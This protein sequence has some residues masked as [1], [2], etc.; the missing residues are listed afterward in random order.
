MNS[1]LPDAHHRHRPQTFDERSAGIGERDRPRS[2][3]DPLIAVRRDRADR[4][5]ASSRSA[6]TTQGDVAGDPYYYAI[7]QAIYAVIGIALMLALARID[8]SRFRELRVGIYTSMIVSI[9]PVLVLGVAT[10]RIARAGSS[11]PSSPSSRRSWA[12]CCSSS[13]WP[14]S[15]STGPGASRRGSAPRGCS[16]S[17]SCPRLIVFVQP[18]S[19]TALVYGVVT[20]AI[21][22]VAGIRWTHFAALGGLALAAVAVVLVI[23]PALGH[24]VLHGYQQER[25]T[26]FL[27]PSDDPGDSSYQTNQALIAVGVRR[28]DRPWRGGD[29]D[30]ERL[31][32]RAPHG[33]HLRRSG[34]AMGVRRRRVPSIPLRPA[35]LAGAADHDS[36]EELVREHD[37]RRNRRDAPVPG[38]RQR[39]DE[40]RA[41]C[42]SRGSPCR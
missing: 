24:P 4:L 26:S 12:S 20:L 13:R 29:T 38:L 37:R 16:C 42:P 8:Y 10:A 35:H 39:G 33:L 27:N 30:A 34:G 40:P 2:R 31:P 28:K 5:S 22:F 6:S 21:L 18:D 36:L 25:L 19:G 3:L 9:A 41:S 11:F 14:A 32:A 15:S 7:R 17:A 1:S 23:A